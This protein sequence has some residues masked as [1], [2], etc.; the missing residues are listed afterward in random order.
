MKSLTFCASTHMYGGMCFRLLR[1]MAARESS[2]QHELNTQLQFFRLSWGMVRRSKRSWRALRANHGRIPDAIDT[3]GVTDHP[4]VFAPFAGTEGY[5]PVAYIP[6]IAAGL[7]G[8]VFGLGFP[9]ILIFMRLLGLAT[10]TAVAAYAI[11]VTPVLKWAF[12]LIA[13]LP[14]SLYNR[15]VLSADG[16]AFSTAMII[17]GLCLR[18]A[19]QPA[20][21]RVW[22]RSLWMTLC[23][24]SKQAQIA[25]ILLEFMVFRLTDLSRRWASV[26]AWSSY[27]P[28][29][30]RRFGCG[31]YQL[32]LVSGA[33]RSKNDTH[34]KHNSTG[35]KLFYMWEHPLQFPLA[36][37][38]AISV[39]GDR[40][41]QE[42]IGIVGWQ[43]I[44]L[45]P[46]VYV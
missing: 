21:G 38:R 17:T 37:W 30:Y 40:L 46:W 26:T 25:F 41:W 10:F 18:A 39:W 20:A 15:S 11:A 28:Q 4:A 31:P 35:T 3:N 16:A 23:A 36:T 7:I 19:W 42:L 24:L 33:C 27:R 6:Y 43:D 44:M 22:Q 8:R 9:D 29:Y 45:Q 1:S 2:F 5:N 34:L 14:V 13:L 32:R 12:V